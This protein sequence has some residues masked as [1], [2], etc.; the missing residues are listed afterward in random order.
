MNN[1]EFRDFCQIEAMKTFLQKLPSIGI[2]TSNGNTYQR[3]EFIRQLASDSVD[4]AE[5]M[6]TAR[7]QRP[8]Y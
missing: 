1:A 6:L 3:Q 7:N 8:T 5:A 4:V 2:P